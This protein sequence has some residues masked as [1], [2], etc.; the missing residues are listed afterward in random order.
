M[1]APRASS[2]LNHHSSPPLTLP[3]TPIGATS[4]TQ[5]SKQKE[6]AVILILG[7][8]PNRHSIPFPI[9]HTPTSRWP[10]LILT[11]ENTHANSLV[12]TYK[13]F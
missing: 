4:N 10:H 6:D 7:S 13:L 11:L 2:C 8:C 3:H 9:P 1:A 12:T 5:N